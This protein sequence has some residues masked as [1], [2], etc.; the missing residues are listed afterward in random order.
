MELFTTVVLLI[1]LLIL[2]Y[3]Q[4]AT[5]EA[6]SLRTSLLLQFL[7]TLSLVLGKSPYHILRFVVVTFFT[8][9]VLYYLVKDSKK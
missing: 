2:F 7:V 3:L 4:R 6:V 1:M 9:S 8:F 5:K